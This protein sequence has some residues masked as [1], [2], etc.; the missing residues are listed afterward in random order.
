MELDQ[1]LASRDQINKRMREVIEEAAVSWGV[2]VTRVR[3]I[4]ALA[5]LEQLGWGLRA[6]TEHVRT[7]RTLDETRA[8]AERA[9]DE[10]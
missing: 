8:W 6:P 7:G 4:H 9:V 3:R 10:N 5:A 1:T 2:D